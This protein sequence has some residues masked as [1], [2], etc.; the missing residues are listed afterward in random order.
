IALT[1]WVQRTDEMPARL[2]TGTLATNAARQM[3][4]EE[5]PAT[6]GTSFAL[7]YAEQSAGDVDTATVR[8]RE[9]TE[10]ADALNNLGVI[11][12]DQELYRLALELEPGHPEASYNLGLADNPSQLLSTY[13][14]G[15]PVVATPDRERLAVAW[16]GDYGSSLAALFT[17]PWAALTNQRALQPQWLWV[18]L[19]VLFLVWVAF[20][21]VTLLIPRPAAARNSPRTLLYHLLALLLPGSGLADELWGVL[22]LVPWAIFG[23]DFLQ[24]YFITTEAGA[25]FSLRTDSIVLI[26]IYII[27]T[28]AFIVAFVSYRRRIQ[29]LRP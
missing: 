16:A 29:M 1:G 2:G 27:N 7:A 25:S 19:V 23:I 9:L 22:L 5:F 8:Y 6:S 18:G 4:R 24:H 28:L 20:T 14:A 3:L 13:R 15:A 10:D 12:G 21:V 11:R 17:N 26:V